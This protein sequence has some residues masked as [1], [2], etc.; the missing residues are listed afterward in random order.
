MHVEQHIKPMPMMILF[1]IAI[2][3]QNQLIVGDGDGIHLR[4]LM[5]LY[6]E[7]LKGITHIVQPI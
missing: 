7:V 1:K 3:F 4:Q 2:I 5:L 6:G